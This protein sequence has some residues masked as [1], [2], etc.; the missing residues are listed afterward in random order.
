M[1]AKKIIE[2]LG[3]GLVLR[4]A[5]KAD[6]EALVQFNGDLHADPGEDFAENVAEWVQDL[7][8][9]PH[10]TTKPQDFTIVEDTKTGE[11][12]SSLNR[13][14]LR[15]LRNEASADSV[16]MNLMWVLGYATVPSQGRINTAAKQEFDYLAARIAEWEEVI[17]GFTNP[18]I[19]EDAKNAGVY[20]AGWHWEDFR[21]FTD[22]SPEKNNELADEYDLDLFLTDNID[23]LDGYKGW[24]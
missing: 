1:T 24:D 9:K 20:P 11:I 3:D 5:N 19:V 18:D 21:G 10:P 2:D 15:N 14:M 17:T 4:R 16:D 8:T 12:V 13:K 23:D 6:A 22:Y 7:M